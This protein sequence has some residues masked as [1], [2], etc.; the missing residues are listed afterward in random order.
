MILFGQ[1]VIVTFGGKMFRT[2]PLSLSEW[3]YIICG[4][5]LMLWLGEM[6][7]MIINRKNKKNGE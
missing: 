7:R 6:W 4:T 3:I 1:W 5:S 2:V